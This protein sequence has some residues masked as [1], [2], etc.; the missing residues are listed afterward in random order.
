MT[1]AEFEEARKTLG[2]TDD[3]VA[4]ELGVTTAVVRGWASGAVPVPRRHAR[5]L[6]WQASI[7]ERQA[8]LRE[9][10][11]PECSWLNAHVEAI[12]ADMGGVERH[13][14]ATEA[15]IA[16]CEICQARDRYLAEHF[17]PL[18]PPPGMAWI[19][20]FQWMSRVPSWARPAVVGA[21]ILVGIVLVRTVFMLPAL[22][23]APGGVG[24]V[25]LAIVAAGGAGAAGGLAY[26]LTRPS[27]RKLGLPGAYLTGIVCVFAYMGTL[28]VAAPYAFGASIVEEPSDLAIF[29]IVSL[30]FG[31]VMGHSW[32]RDPEVM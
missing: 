16:S 7:A 15:H 13:G 25:I 4:A 10:G 11:L 14:R 27:L 21:V 12:P 5:R 24:G 3:E 9:S 23:A 19:G 1:A 6:V 28:A 20:V 22:L 32:F 26:S 2:W 31:M 8:A 18:A 29:G 17:G 30:F